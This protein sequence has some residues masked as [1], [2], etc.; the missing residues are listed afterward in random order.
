MNDL[1]WKSY[2]GFLDLS[3]DEFMEIQQRLL[4]EQINL[5]SK[6]EL[7][8]KI[9]G[10]RAPKT[11]EEFRDRVPLTTYNEYADILINKREDALPEKPAYWIETTWEGGKH[12]VKRAPYPHRMIEEYADYIIACMIM[13]TGD[14]KG[15]FSI[16]KYDKVFYGMAPLP[17]FTGLL[18]CCLD[19][20][21][22][23]EYLP[24]LEEAVAVS[25]KQRNKMGFELGMRKGI[26]V[27][28]SL[29]AVMVKIGESFANSEGKSGKK[30][31]IFKNTF[32]M[33]KR[34]A[35]AWYMKRI[36]HK[37]VLP[38]DIFDV[39]GMICGGTDSAA[40]KDR[41]EYLWGKRPLEIYGGTEIVFVG[42]ETWTKNGLVFFPD[43]NFYE[44][45]PENE[46]IRS[47][48]DPSYKPKTLLFN[49][50][51]AGE[52][53][54][55]VVTNFKGGAFMRYRVGDM[56]KCL[57]LSN[58][59]EGIHV[60]QF[61]YVDRIANVIDIAGFTRITSMTISDSIERSGLKINDWIACKELDENK[62]PRLHIYTELAEKNLSA[63][64]VREH[65]NAALREVDADY[66]ALKSLLG[67]DPLIVSVLHSGTIAKYND[68]Q[69]KPIKKVN[70]GTYVINSILAIDQ[71]MKGS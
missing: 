57:S 14:K 53:Y 10:N 69:I 67:L 51:Q 64:A 66:S 40:F 62:Q 27:I 33:N 45:I 41:I 35:K 61:A 60:P 71:K 23:V 16:D 38:K 24:P 55:I 68:M 56:V 47:M 2:C 6:C 28:F 50:L 29:S 20:Q 19:K 26:D 43:V 1:I 17:F 48:E 12:P 58:Q 25:F 9:M 8:R 31:D 3:I 18:P 4:F 32:N 36:K 22:T 49:E 54:E 37:K 59:A 39:K 42:T 11:V 52:L 7:G 15:A 63:E 46:S 34:L 70:P 13:A 65:L 44:F 30:I 21:L 5:Y